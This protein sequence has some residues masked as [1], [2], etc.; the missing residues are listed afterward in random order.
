MGG[1]LEIL[2]DL[3]Y[4]LDKSGYSTQVPYDA[5]CGAS[6][7]LICGST[8]DIR[9]QLITLKLNGNYQVD[10]HGK[11]AL[12]YIYQHLNSDDFFYNAYQYGYTPNRVMPTNQ[13]SGSYSV[14]V[15]TATYIYTF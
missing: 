11:V 2:G 9:T 12:G 3:S 1:K 8:P 5:T 10:K 6:T 7:K 15:V 4:S 14:N 13:D